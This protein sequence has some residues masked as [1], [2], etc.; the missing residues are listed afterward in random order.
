MMK[1]PL[2]YMNED[3]FE[4]LVV[5]ICNHILGKGTVPF[6]KGKDGGRDGKF[7]GKANS[8]PSAVE[9]WQGKIII[10][11]KH[12]IK[13]NASCSDSDFKSI[14]NNNVIP[15]IK[16]LKASGGIDYYILFTNRRL[17]GIQDNTIQQQLCTETGIPNILIAEEKIQMFLLEYPDVVR[18]AE[19]NRLLLP[20]VFDETDLKNVILLIHNEFKNNKYGKLENSFDYPGL[21]K[22]NELNSLSKEY[23]NSVIQK[24]MEDF[25]QIKR[26]LQAPINEEIAGIYEDAA[27]ELNAKIALYRDQY[28]E[29]EKVL[30]ACYDMV[31]KNNEYALKGKKRLVRTILHYMYCNCDLGRKK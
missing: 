29:F 17:T 5:F 27:S 31:V 26:F 22:K 28:Y 23:F 19:L 4:Q 3:D 7:I 15:A 9:P 11:A 30:E 2:H 24:S 14:I 20:F 8:I 21:D 6:A 16:N 18:S 13:E 10:Q 25:D 1:Y 12:T